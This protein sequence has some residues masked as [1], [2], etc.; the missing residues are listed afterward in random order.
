MSRF[1]KVEKGVPLYMRPA[2]SSFHTDLVWLQR[3]LVE[4]EGLW[5]QMGL[6]QRASAIHDLCLCGEVG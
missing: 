6:A 2:V 5:S 1:L 4:Q 3:G